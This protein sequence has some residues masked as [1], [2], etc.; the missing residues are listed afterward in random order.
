MRRN[1]RRQRY[2]RHRV[3]EWGRRHDLLRVPRPHIHGLRCYTSGRVRGGSDDVRPGLGLYPRVRLGL[4]G[5]GRGSNRRRRLRWQRLSLRH[6]QRTSLAAGI[7]GVYHRGSCFRGRGGGA[8]ADTADLS[9]RISGGGLIIGR[10]PGGRFFTR[11]E[12]SVL[13]PPSGGRSES[14]R[15]VPLPVMRRFFTLGRGRTYA[16]GSGRC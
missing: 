7:V 15:P 13:F 8:I 1:W 14:P 6:S 12:G 10:C 4:C 5:R 16:G 3:G 2:R 11:N 9:P